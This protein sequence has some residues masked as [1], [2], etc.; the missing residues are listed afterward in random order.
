MDAHAACAAVSAD[1]DGGKAATTAAQSRSANEDDDDDGEEGEE[2]EEAA[3]A[4]VSELV[5]AEGALALACWSAALATTVDTLDRPP[6][7]PSWLP[8]LLSLPLPLLAP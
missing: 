7:L 8:G 4:A 1:G 6:L 2:E 3:A 5:S